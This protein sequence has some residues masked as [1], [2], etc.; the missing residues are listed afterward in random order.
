MNPYTLAAEIIAKSKL[1]YR[2]F[3]SVTFVS[4]TGEKGGLTFTSPVADKTLSIYVGWAVVQCNPEDK[5][6]D[7][8]VQFAQW[9]LNNTRYIADHEVYD[10]HAVAPCSI[11]YIA[12]PPVVPAPPPRPP[13]KRSRS[14]KVKAEQL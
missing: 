7:A 9:G 5:K 1:P 12:A 4:H 11:F 14:K 10:L 8:A 6:N 13:K 3:H 2:Y